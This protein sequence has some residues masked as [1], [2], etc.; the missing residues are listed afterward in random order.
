MSIGWYIICFA[1]T[2]IGITKS[3]FGSGLGLIVVPI[4]ALATARIPE[5]GTAASLGLMLPLLI[6]GDLIAL[7]QQRKHASLALVRRLL[8]ATLV[9]IAVGGWFLYLAHKHKAL[10]AALIN[11]DIGLESIILVSLY[12]YRQLKRE[13]QGVYVPK[14]WHNH[15]TGLFAGASSTLAHGAGPII[16]LY[17]LPQKPTRQTFVGTCAVYFFLV[18]TTKL[19]VYAMSGQFSAAPLSLTLRFVPLVLVGGAIGYFLNHRISD[20]LFSQIVYA[21]TFVLGW[22]LLWIGA[23]EMGWIG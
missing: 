17:L 21:G 3:G 19:S 20:R 23:S 9:G 18:N 15:M 14:R 8:P 22:Y 5:L 4:I 1:V 11:L 7:W 2:L 16:A 10:A 13:R 12:W 6:A